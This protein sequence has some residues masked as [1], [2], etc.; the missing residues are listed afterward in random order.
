MNKCDYVVNGYN[1]MHIRNLNEERVID[2]MKQLL[3]KAQKFDNCQICTEDIYALSL[4]HLPPQYVQVGSIVLR[5]SVSDE[6]I[7]AIVQKAIDQVID[8][9]NHG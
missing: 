8:N 5:K 9:P 3:P 7:I 1:L 6:D 4:K 2:A